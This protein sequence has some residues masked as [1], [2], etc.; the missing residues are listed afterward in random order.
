MATGRGDLQC[1]PRVRLTLHLG[2]INRIVR[3]GIA[4]RRAAHRRQ[5]FLSFE[6]L[7]DLEQGPHCV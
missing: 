6:M 5:H 1:A 3:T 7:G 4:V 2:E